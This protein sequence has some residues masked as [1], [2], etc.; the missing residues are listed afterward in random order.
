MKVVTITGPSGVG[1]STTTRLMV[2][3]WPSQFA[4][5]ISVTTRERR[6]HEIDGVDYRFLTDKQF[7]KIEPDLIEK[8]AY[9][10]RRYGIKGI[11]TDDHRTWLAVVDRHGRDQFRALYGAQCRSVLVLPPCMAELRERLV[12]RGDSEEA[13]QHRLANCADE[14]TVDEHYEL[15]V[16]NDS[17]R[18]VA[19]RIF[20]LE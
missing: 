12:E 4:E 7:D 13:I 3:E 17:E 8:V 5:V 9:R 6:E 15:I 20:L 10:G 1:K 14:M 2:N 18:D 19:E 11:D 16:V